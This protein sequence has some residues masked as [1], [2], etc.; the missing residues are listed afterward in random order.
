[1]QDAEYGRS[2]HRAES[3][4]ENSP[5]QAKCRLG[6]PSPISFPPWFAAKRVAAAEPIAPG[7]FR[8][9]NRG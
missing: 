4:K 5:E 9:F 6:L 7:R 8:M 2:S 1:M 3:P